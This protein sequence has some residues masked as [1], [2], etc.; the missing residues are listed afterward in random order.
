MRNEEQEKLEWQT[1][2]II[3]LDIDKT[4]SGRYAWGYEGGSYAHS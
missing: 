3:D 2:E 1:P 4:A